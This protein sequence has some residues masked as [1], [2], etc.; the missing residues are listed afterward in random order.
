MVP[1]GESTVLSPEIA[2]EV[3]VFL[4]KP[5]DDNPY[6]V[7]KAKLIT[8]F[9]AEEAILGGEELLLCMMHGSING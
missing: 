9:R 6:D 5:P 2:T 7:L 8:F 1:T 3:W 4:L